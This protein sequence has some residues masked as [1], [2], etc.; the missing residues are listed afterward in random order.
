MLDPM[1]IPYIYIYIY[2]YIYI[3]IYIQVVDRPGQ[4]VLEL[5]LVRAVLLNSKNILRT[6][7]L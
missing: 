1:C 7:C 2:M 3:Y 5:G 4:V 6:S